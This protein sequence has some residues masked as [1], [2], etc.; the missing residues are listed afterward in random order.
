LLLLDKPMPTPL[1]IP[2]SRA[3][4][5]NRRLGRA[6]RRRRTVRVPT[7][8]ALRASPARVSSACPPG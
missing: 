3:G 5:G 8:W 7:R 6:K 4:A 2:S 1:R